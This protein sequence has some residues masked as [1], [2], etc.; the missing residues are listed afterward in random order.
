VL[1]LP[2]TYRFVV[3]KGDGTSSIPEDRESGLTSSARAKTSAVRNA[4]WKVVETKVSSGVA[5]ARTR[6]K[7]SRP[8]LGEDFVRAAGGTSS[9]TPGTRHV[10]RSVRA[11]V[12]QR[13]RVRHERT[14]RGERVSTTRHESL[15]KAQRGRARD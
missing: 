11:G 14:H 15:H 12:V 3:T 4:V 9:N 7:S 13:R 5:N 8:P 2:L 6:G 1:D 10:G